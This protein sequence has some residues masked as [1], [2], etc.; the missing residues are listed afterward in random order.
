MKKRGEK[1]GLIAEREGLGV[2]FRI[3]A[4]PQGFCNKVS[5]QQQKTPGCKASFL[6]CSSFC[7]VIFS[8]KHVERE[9][10]LGINKGQIQVC[11]SVFRC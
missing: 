10:Y 3:A 11:S 8:Q 2:F 7:T 6:Y 5:T 4:R 1:K 9:I